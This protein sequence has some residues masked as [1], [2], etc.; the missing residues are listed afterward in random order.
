MARQAIAPYHR[1]MKTDTPPSLAAS[2]AAPSAVAVDAGNTDT[3]QGFAYAL[4]AY[5]LWGFLP[6]YLKAIAH[7]PAIEV[8]AHRIL[9]SIPVAGLVLLY[10]RRF[11]ALI[12]ALRTPRLLAMAAL[13]ATLITINWTSYVWAIAHNHAMEA[14]LGYYINPLF[15][16]LLGVLFFGERADRL[17]LFA[18]ALAVLAVVILTV[19]LG[20]LPMVTLAIT[21]SWGFYA[22]FKKHL[23]LGPNQGFMLEVLLLSPAAVAI[24]I[25]IG[26]RGH[27]ATSL[28][29]TLFLAGTGVVTAV[30]LLFY[31]NGAKLLRLS[32]I[33]IMQYL[34]PTM[35]FLTAVFLFHEPFG[36][37]QRIAFPMI[38]AA[39]VLYTFSLLRAARGRRRAR[40]GV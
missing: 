12:T 29:D 30:P 31:A 28:H 7:I 10:Q 9:W 19:S 4:S 25:W 39:L 36:G 6:L 13:T 11:G 37:A 23:P 20:R 2:S 27:F 5:V 8:I 21:L 40:H 26:P 35:V 18:I 22:F 3:P 33:G 1:G 15:S 16:V 32:T 38:W 34:T 14:A 17:Q 24:L